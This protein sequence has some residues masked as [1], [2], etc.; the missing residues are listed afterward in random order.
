MINKSATTTSAP[1]QL[2]GYTFNPVNDETFRLL[3]LGG[4]HLVAMVPIIKKHLSALMAS[5]SKLKRKFVS[6]Q[7]RVEAGLKGRE[8]PDQTLITLF[9][10]VADPVHCSQVLNRGREDTLLAARNCFGHLTNDQFKQLA[11]ASGEHFGEQI[12]ACLNFGGKHE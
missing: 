11:R 1:S 5:K 10:L 9:V 3:T 7:M 2:F 12:I 4:S 6:T 8:T